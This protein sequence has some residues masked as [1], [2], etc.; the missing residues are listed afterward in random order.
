M[1][2]IYQFICLSVLY[3]LGNWEDF[4]SITLEICQ[5]GKF[6]RKEIMGLLANFRDEWNGQHSEK[7]KQLLHRSDI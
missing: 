3:E 2:N 6:I 1:R 5:Q 7:M 4:D